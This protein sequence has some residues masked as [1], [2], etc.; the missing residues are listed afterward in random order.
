MYRFVMLKKIII[1][2]VDY[3]DN[4]VLVSFTLLGPAFAKGNVAQPKKQVSLQ[5]AVNLLND[6]I[7]K[8]VF[9]VVVDVDNLADL[10]EVKF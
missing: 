7:N 5:A 1:D 9:K 10:F 6:A 4:N 2:N 3:D 8:G